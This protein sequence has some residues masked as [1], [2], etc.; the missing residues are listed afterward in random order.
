MWLHF[1]TELKGNGFGGRCTPLRASETASVKTRW[2]FR[3]PSWNPFGHKEV[4]YRWSKLAHHPGNNIIM[5]EAEI[6]VPEAG[7]NG[8]FHFSGFSEC[9]IDW[10]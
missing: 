1:F 2:P 3:S 4:P 7:R 8:F 6:S 5:I 9:T 10:V